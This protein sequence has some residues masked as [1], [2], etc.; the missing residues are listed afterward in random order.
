MVIK[1]GKGDTTYIRFKDVNINSQMI[2]RA[3]IPE[4][5]EWMGPHKTVPSNPQAP[6][7]MTIFV[8]RYNMDKLNALNYDKAE[9]KQLYDQ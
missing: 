8:N 4:T 5:P 9:L 3:D 1:P 7:T 2:A 6:K